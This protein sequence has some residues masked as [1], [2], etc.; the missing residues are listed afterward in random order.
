MKTITVYEILDH[1]VDSPSYFPGCGTTFTEFADC[2][3]GIGDNPQEALEDALETLAQGDWDIPEDSPLSKE[4]LSEESDLPD[5]DG[6]S[7]DGGEGPWHYVSV[8]VR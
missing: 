6:E 3:T 8:R 7:D 5:T 1:G 2:A 4:R